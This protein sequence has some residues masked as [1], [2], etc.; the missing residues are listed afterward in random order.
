LARLKV[1]SFEELRITSPNQFEPQNTEEPV[2]QPHV[3]GTPLSPSTS[4][5]FHNT[6]SDADDT[7]VRH[8]P[9]SG[10]GLMTHKL[11]DSTAPLNTSPSPDTDEELPKTIKSASD[12]SHVVS[13]RH[14]DYPDEPLDSVDK[15][16]A[17]KLTLS[18]HHPSIHWNV[19]AKQEHKVAR[20]I[21]V[22]ERD[23][24]V[25]NEANHEGQVDPVY[26]FEGSS[27]FDDD[28]DHGGFQN[29]YDSET[30]VMDPNE[31]STTRMFEEPS[32]DDEYAFDVP[33]SMIQQSNEQG[34]G[35]NAGTS[36]SCRQNLIVVECSKDRSFTSSSPPPL[37]TSPETESTM[38]QKRSVVDVE[39][40]CPP[41]Q[42]S[43]SEGFSDESLEALF[44]LIETQVDIHSLCIMC[45]YIL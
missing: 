6:T 36:N 22:L 42:K 20:T 24:D 28:L 2:E 14:I 18:I 11:S 27:M 35:Y 40:N 41:N 34:C 29:M 43:S 12:S 13:G 10:Q 39:D 33:L 21:I 31:I 1:K 19:P 44:T 25:Q 4:S 5:I 17:S 32:E 38:K 8:T 15:K 7:E 16:H 9:S 3:Y 30:S 26:K 45:V 23:V 37:T